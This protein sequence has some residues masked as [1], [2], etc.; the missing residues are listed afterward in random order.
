VDNIGYETLSMA[1]QSLA[2]SS[3]ALTKADGFN[4]SF[5]SF[6][7]VPAH[8]LK[9]LRLILGFGVVMWL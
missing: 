3:D 8:S 7:L 1:G 2:L 9:R 6:W 5:R 4:V